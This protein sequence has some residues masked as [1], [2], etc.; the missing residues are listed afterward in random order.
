MV[1]SGDRFDAI[2]SDLIMPEMTGMELHAT[3]A[4]SLPDQAGKMIFMSGGA[5]S[6][7]AAAFLQQVS[8]PWIEKPFRPAVLRETLQKV[9][10]QHGTHH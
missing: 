1:V 10:Q 5:F 9:L 2:L 4:Q 6:P 3:L 7:D 8:P